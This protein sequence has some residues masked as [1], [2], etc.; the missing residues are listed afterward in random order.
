LERAVLNLEVAV[1]NLEQARAALQISRGTL[2]KLIKM[3]HVKALKPGR[4]WLIPSESIREF[5]EKSK[6]RN[7]L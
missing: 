4:K 2:L 7:K 3:G 6:G 1:L 5:L